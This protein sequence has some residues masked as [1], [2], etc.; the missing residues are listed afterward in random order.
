MARKK[1]D[2]SDLITNLSAI[3]SE[4]L[5][6]YLEKW[7][8]LQNR[9][10]LEALNSKLAQLEKGIHR[11]NRSVRRLTILCAVLILWNIFLSVLLIIDWHI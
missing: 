7:A 1:E 2:G 4:L 10:R 5:P 6:L 3:V 11:Q 9:P 8:G